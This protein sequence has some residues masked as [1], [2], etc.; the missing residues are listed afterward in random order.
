M[1]MSV[2]CWRVPREWFPAPAVALTIA[3]PVNAD[4]R[5]MRVSIGSIDVAGAHEK[6]D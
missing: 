1:P 4:V 2:T 5:G 3:A 6:K